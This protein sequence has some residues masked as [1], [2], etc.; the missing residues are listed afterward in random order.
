M[1]LSGFIPSPAKG[2]LHIGPI[3]L[4]AYGL[5]LAIGVLVAATQQGPP[6]HATRRAFQ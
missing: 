5:C 2:I 6:G 4:H 3:P 1:S